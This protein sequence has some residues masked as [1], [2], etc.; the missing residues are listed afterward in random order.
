M[1]KVDPETVGQSAGHEPITEEL[2]VQDWLGLADYLTGSDVTAE[3]ARQRLSDAAHD[4]AEFRALN[5][6]AVLA[7]SEESSDARSSVLRAIMESAR[8]ERGG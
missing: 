6:A 5:R 3:D 8:R 7:E 2:R 1:P 4:T